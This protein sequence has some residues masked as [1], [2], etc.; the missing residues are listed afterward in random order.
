MTPQINKRITKIGNNIMKMTNKTFFTLSLILSL[1]SFSAIATA[2][3]AEINQNTKIATTEQTVVKPK[4]I[5]APK[6]QTTIK[7]S[8]SEIQ[9]PVK[10]NYK[11]FTNKETKSDYA[12]IY[13]NN[14][15][16]VRYNHPAGGYSPEARA[17]IL[18]HR[19]QQFILENGNPK[20]IIP[21]K[22]NNCNIGRAGNT[23]FFTV[24]EKNAEDMGLSTTGLSIH[25]V[26]N[27]REALAAPKIVRGNS[28][29]ASRGNISTTFARKYLGKEEIG[30]ASWYGGIFHGR[31]AAD[32][33]TYNKYE[34]TAAHK[35]LPFGTLVKVTNLRNNKSCIVKITDRGPFV[36][37]RIIDL[38]RAAAKE[39]GVLDSGIAK[40]KVEIIGKH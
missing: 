28:F 20:D 13:I 15:E 25:W 23:I 6:S 8:N 38:S 39:T 17:K 22:E 40:V 33:S 26:N 10:I 16:V 12:T 32:G 14:K 29:I 1:T 35:S 9:N 3:E 30:I 19:L 2:N 31:T 5:Q 7:V 11:I 24:D 21:G 18:V 4:I 36:A 27:I 34:M 37:G